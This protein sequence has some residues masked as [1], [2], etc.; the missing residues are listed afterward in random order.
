MTPAE[1]QALLP[2]LADLSSACEELVST[3]L[4][5]A[6]K[7]TVARLDAAFRE[8]G[9]HRIGRL[10][11]SLRYANEEIGRYVAHSP[12]FSARRLTLFVHR[13]WMV[14]QGLERAV[15]TGDEAL[16]QRL[17]F[18]PTA[19]VPMPS[20]TVAVLGVAARG[21]ASSGSFEF[22][23]RQLGG[24]HDGRALLWSFVFARK[25]AGLP[26]EAWLHLP[27][28]Q[29]FEP[30]VLLGGGAV[31]FTQVAVADGGRLLLGPKATVTVD[32]KTADLTR[33]VGFDRAAAADRVR[34]WEISPL[35]LEVELS[36]E[37][38][39]RDYAVGE[40][41]DRDG[42][43]V[44]PL[45]MDDLPLEVR[46]PAGEDGTRLGKR[47]AELRKRKVV[48]PLFGVMHYEM[49][50]PVFAPLTTFDG[51]PD[52]LT[53]ASTTIDKKKLLALLSL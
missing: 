15:R 9:R 48:P 4:S 37:L 50:R 53:I 51:Q 11:A 28:P 35:D 12:D 20:I 19:P 14:A 8:A 24:E 33:F 31:T 16:W 47:L 42:V 27:Q 49:C 44:V 6:S 3:G 22:R 41:F 36:E 29:K 26:L 30:K 23:L 40:P 10:A 25:D 2:L 32:P 43:R 21:S 34:A 52:F 46:L 18:T 39:L 38:W 1:R 17:W 7:A 13:S 5:A 45:T